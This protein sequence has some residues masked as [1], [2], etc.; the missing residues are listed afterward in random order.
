MV[1]LDHVGHG[2]EGHEV[3]EFGQVGFGLAF[4]GAALAQLGAQRE[5]GVEHDADAG[6]RLAGEVAAGLVG[7]HDHVGLGQFVARQ[8]V[9]GDDG[10]DAVLPRGGGGAPSKA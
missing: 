3:E 7:V 2:A 5:H 6:Q 8:V 10:G 4:E 9:V 1:E